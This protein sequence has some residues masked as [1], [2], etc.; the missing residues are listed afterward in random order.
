MIPR[1]AEYDEEA[2]KYFLIM[3]EIL[4]SLKHANYFEDSQIGVEFIEQFIQ[5][6]L[7]PFVKKKS[8]EIGEEEL[9]LGQQP[10]IL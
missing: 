3:E 10:S 2:A 4:I 7:S 1:Q 6:V 5:Q 8:D 9:T